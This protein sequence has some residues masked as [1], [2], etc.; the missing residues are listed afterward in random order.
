MGHGQG[1]QWTH[2]TNFPLAQYQDLSS[3]KELFSN[4]KLSII[5]SKFIPLEGKATLCSFHFHSLAMTCEK[6]GGQTRQPAPVSKQQ[7]WIDRE[8]QIHPSIID[9]LGSLPVDL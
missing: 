2:G 3:R 9:P 1:T 5:L 6:P 8:K 7:F 4:G